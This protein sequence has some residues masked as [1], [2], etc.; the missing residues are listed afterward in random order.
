MT[1]INKNYEDLNIAVIPADEW[2]CG[3]YRM[4]IPYND[5]RNN[6][7]KNTNIYPLSIF[8]K[9]NALDNVDIIVAQRVIDILELNAI[10]ALQ[11]KGK[12][13][14]HEVD[15]DLTRIQ[16]DNPSYHTY[17]PNAPTFKVFAQAVKDC[18]YLHVTTEYLK[19]VYVKKFNLNP[20]KVKVFN[21]SLDLT[22]SKY[23]ENWRSKFPKDKVI[24]GFQGGSSH[25]NDL[26]NIQSAVKILMD[27]YDNTIF[28]FCSDSRSFGLF[29]VDIHRS[30]YLPPE[31]KK[32]N[33][34]IPIPSIFD[35][36]L[37]PINTID[38]NNAK[39]YL[40]VLEYGAY[41][42]PAVCTNFGDYSEYSKINS[43]GIVLTK[44]RTDKWVKAVERLI[45][46]ENYRHTL[47][48][49]AYSDLVNGNTSLTYINEKRVEFFKSLCYNG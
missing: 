44:N 36:G 21:N 46:D 31:T 34:F 14:V 25:Y 6:Y 49:S 10:K 8:S 33:D 4:Y 15:D 23:K 26:S 43:D 18:D 2:A 27:K 12:I 28:A 5:I 1:T 9:P 3:Q 37:V 7:I 32:F 35:I 42:V 40:K 41:G 48:D 13:F 22:N 47:G 17:R 16:V 38:F 45:I 30:I 29:N 19:S 24:F 39:S 11:A 20:N